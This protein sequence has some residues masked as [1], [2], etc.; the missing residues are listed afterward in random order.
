VGSCEKGG[1]ERL[2]NL[3]GIASRSLRG[4]CPSPSQSRTCIRRCAIIRRR[5]ALE[6]LDQ[7]LTAFAN[8]AQ[9]QRCSPMRFYVVQV[10]DRDIHRSLEIDLRRC[11]GFVTWEQADDF[12]GQHTTPNQVRLGGCVRALN[13]GLRSGRGV[14]VR[15][16]ESRTE[17]RR[18]PLIG[19]YYF[20][21][22]GGPS[23]ASNVVA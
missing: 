2:R 16:F 13:Q 15:P 7:Q 1:C 12:R 11:V 10:A 8:A 4:Q 6:R 3:A 17:R 9:T 18:R 21:F 20:S 22:K 19:L 23:G 14:R 5:G